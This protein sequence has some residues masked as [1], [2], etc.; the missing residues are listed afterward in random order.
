MVVGQRLDNPAMLPVWQSLHDNGFPLVYEIDD[1]PF[2][3]D[4]VNWLAYPN[5]SRT[6]VLDM[7]RGCAQLAD[8]VTVTTKPLAQVFSAFND[9]VVVI[10]NYIPASLLWVNRPVRE[11]LVIGWA[12]GASHSRDLAM[13]AQVWRDV[14]DETGAR[15]H[16]V[17]MNYANMLRPHG[18]TFTPW[19]TDVFDYY[20]L[21][22]F[23]IGLAPIA[24]H[25]F[26]LSKSHIK[27][28]EYAAL[29]I[30]VVA[31]DCE[32]YRDF[33]IDGVTGFLVSTQ[34]QWRDA[35][36]TL[37]RDWRLRGEMS[38]KARQHAANWTIEQ[39]WHRWASAYEKLL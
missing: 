20:K 29:G 38:R 7:I 32:A 22:D 35:I 15:G 28:L 11:K 4:L 27:C 33:V 16:F 21:L 26:A 36:M 39:H 9:N 8:L 5:F 2:S 25:P 10:P 6:K 1:D 37:A 23:D 17:G 18:F 12:G 34:S 14:V 19:A 13:I 31:S 3:V 30:P 24:E